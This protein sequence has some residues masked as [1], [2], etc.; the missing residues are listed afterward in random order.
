[1]TI[2]N[3]QGGFKGAGL[4]SFDPEKVISTLDLILKILMPPNSRPNITYTWVPQIP[5]N[6]AEALS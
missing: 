1:M 3:I 2:S 4:I 5:N 6:L